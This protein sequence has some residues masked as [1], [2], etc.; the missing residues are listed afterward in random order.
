MNNK[1]Q[2]GVE[3]HDQ[4]FLEGT[5]HRENL[6]DKFVQNECKNKYYKDKVGHKR[7]ILLG[8]TK[9]RTLWRTITIRVVR[10]ISY[11]KSELDDKF[12]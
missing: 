10:N 4:S 7:E 12:Q 1:K 3:N 6:L 8:K 11:R 5:F 9:E 2:E